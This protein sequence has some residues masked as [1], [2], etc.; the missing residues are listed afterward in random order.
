MIYSSL[1]MRFAWQI[2]PRNY[3][4]CS[5]HGANVLA[6]ANL[7]RIKKKR[8]RENNEIANI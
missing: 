8:E 2:K 6:Q 7:L 3:L 4:L 5:C 1:F